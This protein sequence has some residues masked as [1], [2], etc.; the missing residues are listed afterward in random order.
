MDEPL[1]DHPVLGPITRDE[2]IRAAVQAGYADVVVTDRRL[3]IASEARLML[4]V[5]M[6]DVRRIQFDIERIHPATLVI[7]PEY[8]VHPPQ[9]LAVPPDQYTRVAD[10]LVVLGQR[11]AGSPDAES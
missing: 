4:D 11:L 2:V 7:V 8:S 9:V 3:V 5:E 1:R 10:L 6:D